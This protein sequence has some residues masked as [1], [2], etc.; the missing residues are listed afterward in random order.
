[1][2]S[3]FGPA[4]QFSSHD[5][6]PKLFSA[7][8]TIAEKDSEGFGKF[9]SD[10]WDVVDVAVDG[11]LAAAGD[12]SGA[13]IGAAIGGTAGTIIAGAIGAAVGALAIW[14]VSVIAGYIIQLFRDDIFMPQILQLKF[15]SPPPWDFANTMLPPWGGVKAFTG[16]DGTYFL[17]YHWEAS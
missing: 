7:I 4:L 13:A 16:F 6:W 15:A 8:I 14:I 12:K 3:R 5:T 10:L 9:L 2:N 11:A 1:M 17:Y